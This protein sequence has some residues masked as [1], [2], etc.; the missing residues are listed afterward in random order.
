MSKPRG[1][2]ADA[3][4]GKTLLLVLGGTPERERRA[5]RACVRLSRGCEV[6]V[7]VSGPALT[8]DCVAVCE[9]QGLD[10]ALLLVDYWALDTLGNFSSLMPDARAHGF[11]EVRVVTSRVH[12]RR[13]EAVAAVVLPACGLRAGAT[14]L[15]RA[16]P[17]EREE[18]ALLVW[19][20]WLRA[21]LWALLGWDITFPLVWLVHRDRLRQRDR[22]VRRWNYRGERCYTAG[23]SL[24]APLQ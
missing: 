20:D 8:D 6:P 7:W 17:D 13:A 4:A 1:R 22:R 10:P 2:G 5:V 9:S 19:R 14:V 18:S 24:P 21:L 3:A 15:V 23:G 16:G 12:A 11:T